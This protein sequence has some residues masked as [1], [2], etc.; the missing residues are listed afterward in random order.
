MLQRA[1]THSS[2]G[3]DNYERMEFLGDALLDFVVGEYL[4]RTYP[5]APEGELSKRRAQMVSNAVLCN[6]F[7]RFGLSKWL[8]VQNL[9]LRS[10]S[11]KLRANFIESIV[12]AV[13]L[14]GGLHEATRF[15]QRFICEATVQNTDYVSRLYEYCAMGKRAL[16]V[17]EL[18]VGTATKPRFAVTVAVDGILLGAAEADSIRH[19]KANAC[20]EA[21][22]KLED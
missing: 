1:L 13:Y 4:Y 19:A 12:A 5:A 18:A 20:R 7:D 16:A 22:G 3:A 6:L 2:V 21:L 14:D 10:L 9:S 17:N 11:E 15:I 8:K